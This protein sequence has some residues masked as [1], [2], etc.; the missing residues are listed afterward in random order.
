VE[1]HTVQAVRCDPPFIKSQVF[2]GC[3]V[4]GL[5][6]VVVYGLKVPEQKFVD[7]MIVTHVFLTW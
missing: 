7:F 5:N 4:I 6:V 3:G 1:R 2:A